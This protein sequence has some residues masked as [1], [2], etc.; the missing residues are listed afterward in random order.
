MDLKELPSAADFVA[1]AAKLASTLREL[2]EAPVVE[3]EYRG[4]VLFS[5]DASAD[6]FADLVGENVLGRKPEL[7]KNA[8][9]TGAFAS[10]YKTRV[11]PD[12][13]SVID[14]PTI[15]SYRGHT[16]L[17]HYEIDDEGVPAQR[18]S[19]VEKGNLVNYVIGRQPIRDFPMSNGHGRARVPNNPAGQ[20]HRNCGSAAH[21][22]CLEGKIPR[23][24]Q[25]AR[26]ALLL[27][28]RDVRR[29]DDATPSLPY[30]CQR[31]T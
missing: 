7:G 16:L 27:L 18:V 20:S 6:I 11:L 9:T 28:R 14:D 2:R 25:A 3:E 10:S 31:R 23:D 29:P 5:G 1:R 26:S 17:G 8:R 19:L 15:A 22:R 30:L 24:V 21:S 12:F 13:L 4:P